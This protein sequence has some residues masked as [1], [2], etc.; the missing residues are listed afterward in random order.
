MVQYP[1]RLPD[2]EFSFTID[3]NIFKF[4][5]DSTK[6]Y[7]GDPV[8]FSFVN[9]TK[10]GW[11]DM[12]IGTKD[13]IPDYKYTFDFQES[14]TSLEEQMKRDAA[15]VFIRKQSIPFWDCPGRLVQYSYDRRKK[16]ESQFLCFKGLRINVILS[17]N[18]KTDNDKLLSEFKTAIKAIKLQCK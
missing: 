1:I 11:F 2:S 10:D 16:I 17:A 6:V 4:E 18:S 8:L 9:K 15:N 14:K 3:T 5:F 12:Y 13:P 7:I